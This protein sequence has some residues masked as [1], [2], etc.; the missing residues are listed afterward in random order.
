MRKNLIMLIIACLITGF[1]SGFVY[2]K[3]VARAEINE[4]LDSI[5][6]QVKEINGLVNKR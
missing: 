4:Q 5:I 1:G 6:N 3:H 2:G